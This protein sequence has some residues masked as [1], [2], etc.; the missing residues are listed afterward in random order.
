MS[1]HAKLRSEAHGCDVSKELAC[2]NEVA[3]ASSFAVRVN[4]GPCNFCRARRF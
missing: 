2:A 3:Q 4:G 1:P